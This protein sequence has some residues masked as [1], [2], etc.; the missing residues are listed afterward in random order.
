[1]RQVAV[2]MHGEPA[3]VLEESNDRTTYRFTYHPDYSGPPISLN[4]PVEA[5]VFEYEH[6]PPFFDGLLPEGSMLD[7]LLVQKKIDAKDYI[8]QLLVVGQDPVG[9]V[10]V[11]VME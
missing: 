2:L 7:A 10:T 1:M 5:E 6:F 11:E 8:G 4:M 3:G 9:A